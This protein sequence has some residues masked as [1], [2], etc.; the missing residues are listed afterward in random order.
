MLRVNIFGG[1]SKK[2]AMDEWN[3]LDN[4]VKE[5]ILT[6]VFCLKCHVTT[7][8]DYEIFLDKF[9]IVLKGKCKKCGHKVARM[10]ENE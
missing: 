10:I 8:V 4:T 6:N 3:K 7:I 5:Q 9:G 1:K 2:A